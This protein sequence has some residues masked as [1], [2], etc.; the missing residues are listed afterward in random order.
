MRMCVRKEVRWYEFESEGI[1]YTCAGECLSTVCGFCV[2]IN[3]QKSEFLHVR[4]HVDVCTR[5][6]MQHIE[7]ECNITSGVECNIR[8][9][10]PAPRHC[11]RYDHHNHRHHYPSGFFLLD[12]S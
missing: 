10:C 1:L 5:M 6:Y 7:C 3:I 9:E 8:N 12:F 4:T 2:D 11:L